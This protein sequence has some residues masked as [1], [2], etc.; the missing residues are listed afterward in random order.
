MEAAILTAAPKKLAEPL[1]RT[2]ERVFQSVDYRLAI[3]LK[4]NS[5]TG[6]FQPIIF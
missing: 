6:V 3:L 5:F 4:M 2:F 1:K